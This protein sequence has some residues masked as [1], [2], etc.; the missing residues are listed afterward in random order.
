MR[1]KIKLSLR[2]R[3]VTQKEV[4]RRQDQLVEAAKR[5]A[6]K[7][8]GSDADIVVTGISR[9]TKFEGGNTAIMQTLLDKYAQAWANKYQRIEA[10]FNQSNSWEQFKLANKGR[11]R[12]GYRPNIL[13]AIQHSTPALMTGFLK[14]SL[15]QA[16]RNGGNRYLS[17]G[18]LLVRGEFAF[19]VDAFP[20]GPRSDESYV[21]SFIQ[22]LERQIADINSDDPA[23]LVDFAQEDWQVIAIETRRLVD[24]GFLGP[25]EDFLKGWSFEL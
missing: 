7:I 20:K 8:F 6:V 4:A 25:I 23:S 15:D 12:P 5:A 2:S 22:H 18:N 9:P 14:G 21:R 13:P 10:E 24:Q 11:I 3:A 16:F 1:I 19:D 17:L